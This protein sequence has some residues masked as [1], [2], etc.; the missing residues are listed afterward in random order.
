MSAIAIYLLGWTII[1]VGLAVGAYL[2]NVP[3]LWAGIAAAVL[4]GL[5]ALAVAWRARPPEP[6]P[7]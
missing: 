6:P 4:I 7:G 2:L 5:A 3:A 1:V